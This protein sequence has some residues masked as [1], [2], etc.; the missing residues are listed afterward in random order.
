MHADAIT[1][2]YTTEEPDTRV[3]LHEGTIRLRA[4]DHEVEGPGSVYLDWQPTP[5]VGFEVKIPANFDPDRPFDASGAVPVEVELPE[6]AGRGQGSVLR[7]TRPVRRSTHTLYGAARGEFLIGNPCPT[8]VV[9]F[10]IPNFPWFHGKAITSEDGVATW[11]GR[12]S[13]TTTEWRIDL[14]AVRD[15]ANLRRL[16]DAGGG[17]AFTHVGRL[18]RADDEAVPFEDLS[19]ISAA[20]D[21]WLSLLRSERSSPVLMA[22]VHR[23]EVTWEVWRTP[24]I[25]RWK[26]R[27]SWLPEILIG[28]ALGGKEVDVG[29][30][31][32]SLDAMRSD[33]ELKSLVTLAI[34]WYTQAVESNDISTT[35]ILAQAG[36]E[37]M[38]WL[39]LA[40]GS[41]ISDESFDRFQAADALRIA[42]RF[43][44]IDPG[45]PTS[46]RSLFKATRK[47]RQS[48]EL[49]GPGGIT[50][51]RNSTIH[52][53]GG[54]RFSDREVVYEGGRIAIHYLEL[55][56]LNQLGYV[57]AAINRVDESAPTLVPWAAP[58]LLGHNS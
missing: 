51:I 47:S 7:S 10:H 6:I 53:R 50:A 32:E 40:R 15:N 17:Y 48:V 24:A 31:L 25:A 14:D 2:L 58:G 57:G 56:I 1:P 33:S 16:L 29:P 28:P 27:H 42:L 39:C 18:S 26:L 4:G 45:V 55:L 41:G 35:I 13:A 54:E 8:E 22:G 23:G 9:L 46:A 38:S 3:I 43:A 21:S 36:L 34:D 49:D 30:I 44:S 19:R 52:P 37:L 5:R 12:L 11:P 20:L